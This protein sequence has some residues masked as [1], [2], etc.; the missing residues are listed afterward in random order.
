MKKTWENY[1]KP[2]PIFWRKVGDYALLIC[3]FLNGS[4]M[5]LPVKEDIKLWLIFIIGLVTTTIKFWANTKKEEGKTI[6]RDIFN[7]S[8]VN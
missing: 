7:E 1:K 8:Q 6:N 3:V 5:S 4:I 2:V